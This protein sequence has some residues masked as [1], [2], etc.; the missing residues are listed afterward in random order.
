M[1]KRNGKEGVGTGP[2]SEMC[3]RDR[4]LVYA[5]S[6]RIGDLMQA[7]D[8][9][10][11][12]G[13]DVISMSWGEQERPGQSELE[14]VFRLYPSTAFVGSA[15]DQSAVPFFPSTSGLVLSAGGTSLVLSDTGERISEIALSLIH[16]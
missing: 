2:S 6:D 11:G 9:A 12:L 16:I 14:R 4:L 1:Q 13:A 3:I 15:G 5:A 7:A 8:L 10:A